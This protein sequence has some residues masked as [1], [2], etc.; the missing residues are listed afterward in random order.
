MNAA[1]FDAVF[2]TGGAWQKQRW[3][4]GADKGLDR[5]DVRDRAEA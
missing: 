1:E 4:A 3:S 2:M 5:S